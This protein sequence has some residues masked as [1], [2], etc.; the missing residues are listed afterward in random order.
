MKAA[1]TRLTKV[2]FGA[3]WN[4]IN[5]LSNAFLHDEELANDLDAILGDPAGPVGLAGTPS[6]RRR[7][8]FRFGS[9]KRSQR[10]VAELGGAVLR[11]DQILERL[12]NVAQDREWK[13]PY[14]NVADAIARAKRVRAQRPLIVGEFKADRGQLRRLAMA[15]DDLLGRLTGDGEATYDSDG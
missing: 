8:L 4:A 13:P 1:Q 10:A 2:E 12:V 3:A 9:S 14:P 6:H 5:T 15:A 11:L 7:G